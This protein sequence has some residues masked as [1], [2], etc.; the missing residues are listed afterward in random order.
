MACTQ[1]RTFP[2]RESLCLALSTAASQNAPFALVVDDDVLIRM[3]AADILERAGFR[4]LEACAAAEA[5]QMLET[6]AGRVQLLFTDV[7]ML[8]SR[9]GFALASETAQRWPHVKILV[10]SGNIEPQPDDM[11]EHAVFIGKPFS[12]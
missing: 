9:D 10:A 11:P 12:R 5:L 6:H 2:T 7:E 8:G 3:D 4:P 1:T